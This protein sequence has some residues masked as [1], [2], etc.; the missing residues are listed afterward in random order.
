MKTLEVSEVRG[1]ELNILTHRCKFGLK[2]QH[3]H[4]SAVRVHLTELWIITDINLQ[5][6]GLIIPG[7]VHKQILG[8]LSEAS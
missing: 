4:D 7:R 5:C 8:R 2:E 1:P 6:Q 3:Y